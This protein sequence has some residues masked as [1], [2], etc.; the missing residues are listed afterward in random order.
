METG[1]H[2]VTEQLV[3]DA[4]HFGWQKGPLHIVVFVQGV[5]RS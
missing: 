1:T 3:N 2:L 5:S 4:Q